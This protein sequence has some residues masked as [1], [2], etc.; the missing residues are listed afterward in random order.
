MALLVAVVLVGAMAGGALAAS[1]GP[2]HPGTAANDNSVGTQA[3]SNLTNSFSQNNLY[4]D[5]TVTK[6]NPTT[7]YL[8][9]TNFSFSIPTGAVIDGIR[10]EIDRYSGR[11]ARSSIPASR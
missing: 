5:A 8:K 7:Q 9:L 4:A 11:Q 3:W 1:T 10:V 6:A 2:N